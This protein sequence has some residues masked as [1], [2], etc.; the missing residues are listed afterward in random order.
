MQI[1]SYLSLRYTTSA[2]LDYLLNRTQ[3]WYFCANDA[4][5]S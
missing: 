1:F 3:F 2:R 5:K 4:N